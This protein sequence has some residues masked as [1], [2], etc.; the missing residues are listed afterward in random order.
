MKLPHRAPH[1]V[2][3]ALRRDAVEGTAYLLRIIR[4]CGGNLAATARH[5]DSSREWVYHWIWQYG[6]QEQVRA[7]REDMERR[8]HT[9]THRR[10][11]GRGVKPSSA[12]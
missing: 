2:G 7:I 12:L 4:Q 10:G 6:L 11:F 3:I 1:R 8:Y 5:I 9:K